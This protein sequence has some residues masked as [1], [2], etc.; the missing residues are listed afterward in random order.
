MQGNLT[1]ACG[2]VAVLLALSGGARAQAPTGSE[3]LGSPHASERPRLLLE[4]QTHFGVVQAPFFTPEFPE[5]AAHGFV[6]ALSG[7]YRLSPAWQVGIHWPLALLS[8]RQP[9]GSY[10]DESAW[11]NPSLLLLHRTSVEQAGSRRLD[12]WLG[13]E[14]GVPLAESGALGS[15]LENRALEAA[16]ALEAYRDPEAFT[17]GTLAL[18]PRVGVQLESGRFALRAELTT[19]FLIRVADA[20]LPQ[21]SQSHALGL[22]PRFE[23]QG[24]VQLTRFVQLALA[25][26]AT[27][28]LLRVVDPVPQTSRVQFSLNPKVQFGLARGFDLGLT[29]LAPLVGPLGGSTFAGGVEL[30]ARWQ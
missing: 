23:L 28:A 5:V 12:A 14:L 8:L 25:A 27:L 16:N 1:A 15:L 9:A 21:A 13:F 24:S 26:N 19:P 20:A 11:G 29:F 30:Q 17:P 2:A 10:L 6:L 4:L 22:W 18:S 7:Q 3:P